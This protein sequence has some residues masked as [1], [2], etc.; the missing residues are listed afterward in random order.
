[1]RIRLKVVEARIPQRRIAFYVYELHGLSFLILNAATRHKKPI[2]IA[3]GANTEAY[4]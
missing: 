2:K 3:N 4:Q 1:M